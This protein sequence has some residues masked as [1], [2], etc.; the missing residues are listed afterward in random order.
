MKQLIELFITFMKVGSLTFGGGYA[1]LPVIQK[2]VVENKGWVT[3]E[4][5]VEYYAIGQCTPGL[6]AVNTATFVGNHVAGIPGG[7]VATLGFVFPAFIVICILAG[8]IENFADL[9]VVRNAFAGIRVCACVLIFNAVIKMWKTSVQDR[10]TFL[11]FAAV[12]LLTVVCSLSPVL[13]VMAA[14]A[15]GLAGGI[16]LEKRKPDAGEPGHAQEEKP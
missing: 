14:A 2:E 7:I 3:D 8:L 6:I 11:I 5:L 9:P 15:C 10:F 4:E 13:L 12:F 16:I 1:M